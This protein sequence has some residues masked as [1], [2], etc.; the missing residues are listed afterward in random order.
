MKMGE[1]ECVYRKSKTDSTPI[2]DS[3]WLAGREFT[4]LPAKFRYKGALFSVSFADFR[5]CRIPER[6]FLHSCIES[7]GKC[8]IIQCVKTLYVPPFVRQSSLCCSV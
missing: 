7:N 6:F 2:L 8:I 3:A 1:S 4:L 5:L